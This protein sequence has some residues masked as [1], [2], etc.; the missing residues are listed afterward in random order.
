VKTELFASPALGLN[1]FQG[2]NASLGWEGTYHGAAIKAALPVN[3]GEGCVLLLDPEANK[4]SVFKNLLRV[5]RD[6][7]PKWFADLPRTSDVFID[8][9]LEDRLSARTWS[10]YKIIIDLSSGKYLAQ[11]FVK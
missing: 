5:G 4:E 1:V 7:H 11:E 2:D 8:M 6:G 3:G 9:L 10:G